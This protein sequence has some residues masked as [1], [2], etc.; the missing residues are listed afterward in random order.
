MLLAFSRKRDLANQVENH[1]TS[2]LGCLSFGFM[3]AGGQCPRRCNISEYE[4][5]ERLLSS[6]AQERGV[7]DCLPC[8]T[9]LLQAH[10]V[11]SSDRLHS[12]DT[13]GRITVFWRVRVVPS[14]LF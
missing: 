10:K 13:S 12:W 1:L 4:Q 14:T 9:E 5:G 8:S 2:L 3:A 11:R 6:G 7:D